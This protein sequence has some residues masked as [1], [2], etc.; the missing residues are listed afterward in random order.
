MTD[1]EMY[2]V[3]IL[4]NDCQGALRDISGIMTGHG[5][6]IITISASV[7]ANGEKKGLYN[8]YIEFKPD[9]GKCS[10]S[11]ENM[12]VPMF[13]ELKS[14]SSV[15][16]VDTY[17]PLLKI[18]GKRVIII[19]GGAQ[20]AQVAMGAVNEADR[21]NIRGEKISVDTIPI[22]GEMDLAATIDAVCRLPRVSILVLAGSL[23]GGEITNSV[24]RVRSMGI[25]VISLNMAGSVAEHA[26]LV[27]TDPIQA[28][29]FAVMHISEKGVFDLSRVRGRVF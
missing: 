15:I 11:S 10:G 23:M 7:A 12:L 29:V 6:D 13:S 21:H 5:A 16:S 4:S 3:S 17:Q 26:D 22:V 24:K 25:P 9:L 2:A 14:L 18:F 8:I 19:G 28:G 27:V 1:S 20:V